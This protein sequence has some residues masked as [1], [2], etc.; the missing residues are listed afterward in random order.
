MFLSFGSISTKRIFT[1]IHVPF[2]GKKKVR[3]DIINCPH[4]V[5]FSDLLFWIVPH[6]HNKALGIW[7]HSNFTRSLLR[8][9]AWPDKNNHMSDALHPNVNISLH[10]FAATRQLQDDSNGRLPQDHIQLGLLSTDSNE[11]RSGIC[12]CNGATISY[13]CKSTTFFCSASSCSFKIFLCFC[14]AAIKY[15]CALCIKTSEI[16]VSWSLQMTEIWVSWSLKTSDIWVSWSLQT[17]EICSRTNVD[18][19]LCLTSNHFTATHHTVF[20]STS[21]P[22]CRSITWANNLI[23][24]S[25]W[26]LP[27]ILHHGWHYYQPM[28]VVPVDRTALENHAKICSWRSFL[29]ATSEDHSFMLCHQRPRALYRHMNTPSCG[30]LLLPNSEPPPM[31][32]NA[33]PPQ[34]ILHALHTTVQ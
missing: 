27:R 22:E 26:D 34:V 10:S 29:H 7:I 9:T 21:I 30:C 3:Q 28:S 23:I 12:R 24:N 15:D 11:R 8:Y 33:C 19:R 13:R 4:Q 18:R 1:W 32:P 5:L 6:H 31:Q 17:T 14:T 2:I 25:F 16:W 20:Q